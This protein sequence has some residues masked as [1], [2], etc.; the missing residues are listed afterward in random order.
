MKPL[1]KLSPLL[2][3]ACILAGNL[4]AQKASSFTGQWELGGKQRKYAAALILRQDGNRYPNFLSGERKSG[5]LTIRQEADLLGDAFTL[6]SSGGLECRFHRM[7]PKPGMEATLP[8][9]VWGARLSDN[10][11]EI[12]I[13]GFSDW[14]MD[15]EPK[16]PTLHAQT[17]GHV[18]I[19]GKQTKFAGITTFRFDKEVAKWTLVSKCT[20]S[21]KNLGLQANQHGNIH[22]ELHTGSPVSKQNP[23]FPSTELKF[24]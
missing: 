4:P 9:G 10:P 12:A 14:K 18:R 19:A 1:P 17:T 15:T 7:A 5:N 21:G 22:F 13:S 16:H 24:E 3:L 11:L 6:H 8:G 20:F 23:D 2:A